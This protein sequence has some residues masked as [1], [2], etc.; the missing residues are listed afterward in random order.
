MIGLKIKKKTTMLGT[1]VFS[2]SLEKRCFIKNR[3]VNVKNRKIPSDL[4]IVQNDTSTNAKIVSLRPYL[5]KSTKEET[6]SK[7]NNGSVIPN[8]EFNMILGSKTNNATP[9]SAILSSKNLLHRK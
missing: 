5:K 3:I 1:Y 2:I 4:T 9:I 7:M 6:P 8:N